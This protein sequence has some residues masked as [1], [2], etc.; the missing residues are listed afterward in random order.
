MKAIKL[1]DLQH[2]RLIEMANTLFPG[3][4]WF[5]WEAD[6]AYYPYGQMF[7]HDDYFNTDKGKTY[8]STEIHWVEFMVYH[9]IPKLTK[10]Y[11]FHIYVDIPNEERNIIDVV[12]DD[13]YSEINKPKPV[14]M[15]RTK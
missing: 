5:F 8:P 12:Y 9:L 10:T 4:N 6:V 1:T 2:D 13:F 7:G 11:D 3:R 15:R 14:K